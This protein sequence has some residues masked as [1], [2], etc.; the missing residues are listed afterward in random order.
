MTSGTTVNDLHHHQEED[1]DHLMI[2][3][4]DLHHAVIVQEDTENAHQVVV[5]LHLMN[6]TIGDMAVGHLREIMAHPLHEDM[7]NPM[8]QEDH[9]HLQ[10]VAMVNHIPE[11]AIRTQDQEARL[12]Q[13][14]TDMV[15]VTEDMMTDAIS[16]ELLR[17]ID[18]T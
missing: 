4:V 9:L 11:M 16:M 12:H 3:M 14:D 6:T 10:H 1:T 8:M 2:I 18:Y 17:N 5:H 15:V 7:T 13:E